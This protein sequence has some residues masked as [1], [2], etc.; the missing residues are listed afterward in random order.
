MQLEPEVRVNRNP[1][2]TP[3]DAGYMSETNFVSLSISRL[4]IL[5]V[6]SNQYYPIVAVLFLCC[7]AHDLP[8]LQCYVSKTSHTPV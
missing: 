2:L 4:A 5:F 8:F 6:S 3:K 7:R 1:N